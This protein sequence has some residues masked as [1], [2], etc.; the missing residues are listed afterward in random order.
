MRR[1]DTIGAAVLEPLSRAEELDL[2]GIYIH[3]SQAKLDFDTKSA[4]AN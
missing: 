1:Y 3:L 4:M 2:R